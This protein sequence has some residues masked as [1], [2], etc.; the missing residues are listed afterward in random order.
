LYSFVI[1][2]TEYFYKDEDENFHST[3]GKLYEN[4]YTTNYSGNEFRLIA[5]DA[6]SVD[7]RLSRVVRH[8]V[9]RY[10][11]AKSKAL[12]CISKMEYGKQ[13]LSFRQWTDKF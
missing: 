3:D 11:A 12:A 13:E 1:G 2:N 10:V 9:F 8:S 5:Q 7:H 6:T 4:A